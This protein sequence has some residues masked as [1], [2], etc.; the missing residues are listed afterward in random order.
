MGKSKMLIYDKTPEEIDEIIREYLPVKIIEK[1]KYGEV[2]TPP[3]LIREMLGKLP[4]SVWKNK[5]LKWLDP[6][7]GTGNF[8]MIVYKKLDVGLET[9]IPDKKLRSKHIIDNMLYMVELNEKN[10]AVS[11]KIFGR[12]ANIACANFLTEEDKW[13]F[14]GVDKFD[15]IMG[16]PPWNNPKGEKSGTQS[17]SGELWTKFIIAAFNN[18]KKN[19]FLCFIHPSNWRGLGPKF[20]KIWDLLSEKQLLYL[21]IYDEKSGS[22]LFG[23]SIRFDIYVL[24]NKPNTKDT[25]VIDKLKNKHHL[26]LNEWVF[27]PN[28]DYKNIKKIINDTPSE[29]NVIYDSSFYHTQNKKKNMKQKKQED[30]KYPVVHTITQGGELNCWYTNDKATGH[31]GV[32]KV[33]LTKS[34]HQY[35][36]NDYKGKYGMSQVTF[37]IPIKSKAEGDKIVKAINSPAFKGIIKASKWSTGL[38]ET[39]YRMFKYFKPGFYK[40]NIFKMGLKKRK[41]HLSPSPPKK[42]T[43]KHRLS[44]SPSKKHTRKRNDHSSPSKKHTMKRKGHFV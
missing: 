27:F 42:H 37:G 26:K 29:D 11:R 7:N 4:E 38:P 35:P 40:N 20:R 41:H 8:P 18:L 39:D 1:D 10:V 28:Y 32:P 19:G 16:N 24:Q 33:L 6:A 13:K 12:D 34:R 3:S 25:E 22:D 31:F 9:V 43:I 23:V 44:P 2:F 21:H 14:E 36:Y 5:D 17:K 15:I 30:F